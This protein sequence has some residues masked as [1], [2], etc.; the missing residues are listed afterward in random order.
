[1][2]QIKFF[3]GI[4]HYRACL[5]SCPIP[6][7]GHFLFVSLSS[8]QS[9]RSA[10]H[11]IPQSTLLTDAMKKWK[12]E[13][14]TGLHI[15]DDN[16]THQGST[17]KS[18][19]FILL[20]FDD[21]LE[22][23]NLYYLLYISKVATLYTT[24]TISITNYLI[25]KLQEIDASEMHIEIQLISKILFLYLNVFVSIYFISKNFGRSYVIKSK[26][27]NY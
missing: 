1:M 24:L 27:Y 18:S 19:H 23:H 21:M 3:T 8:H 6:R 5:F 26:Y 9:Q 16:D 25:E 15:S 20:L 11:S 2:L 4:Q 22:S 14:N 13:I 17:K 7:T 12:H 10:S